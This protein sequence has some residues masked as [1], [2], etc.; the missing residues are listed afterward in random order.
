MGGIGM[1]EMDYCILKRE[2]DTTAHGHFS[3][4]PNTCMATIV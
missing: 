4:T 1:V 3:T 2:L